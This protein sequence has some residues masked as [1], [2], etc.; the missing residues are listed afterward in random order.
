MASRPISPRL[1]GILDYATGA[2]LLVLPSL[3]RLGGSRSARVL[4]A[5]GVAHLAYA[6]VTDY[7]LG[8]VKRLPFRTHLAIDAA[9]AGTLIAA[10]WLLGTK[11][12][13]LRH[14]LPQL[15]AGLNDAVVTALTDPSGAGAGGAT[16]GAGAS[17]G[18]SGMPR[19]VE[20]SPPDPAAAVMPDG[21]E[22]NEGMG[23]RTIAAR[24]GERSS[25]G[26]GSGTGPGSDPKLGGLAG[27]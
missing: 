4:R 6:A 24:G 21:A 16:G 10:P 22:A 20:L 26:V 7:E 12:E 17:A 15:L 23:A 25:G 19:E 2:Q 18:A 1:H 8:L 13:G 5:A 27:S 9:G 3:L 14:W 11:R